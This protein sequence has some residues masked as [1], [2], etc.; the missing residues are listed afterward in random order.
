MKS[1][2][3]FS[4]LKFNFLYFLQRKFEFIKNNKL[5]RAFKLLFLVQV[6]ISTIFLFITSFAITSYA[7]KHID[8][9][10]YYYYLIFFIFIVL[11]P[12]LPRAKMLISPI[13]KDL[14]YRVSIKQSG[15]FNL[16]YVS[17]VLKKLPSYLNFIAI[18][19]GISLNYPNP[20][21]FI[22]KIILALFYFMCISYLVQVIYTNI[23]VKSSKKIL[24]FS[25]FFINIILGISVSTIGFVIS[26]ILLNIF[27]KPFL[28]FSSYII[29]SKEKFEWANYLDSIQ[30]QIINIHNKITMIFD[31]ISPHTIFV[32]VN[33]LNILIVFL[34]FIL[35]ILLYRYN[36]IGYWYRREDDYVSFSN[37]HIPLSTSLFSIQLKQLLNNKEEANLHK[38][39]FYISY[40]LWFFIGSIMYF[41][42]FS[43]NTLANA[44]IFLIILNTVTRDS[45]SAGI[46]LFTK[47]L[48]FDSDGKS[49]GI[50]RISNTSFKKIYDTKIF[51]IRL[52]G[53]KETLIITIFL[54]L[55]LKMDM[56]LYIILGQIIIINTII[57]PNLSLLPSY[58]SPH[59][60]HQH[61]SEFEYF[62]DQNILEDSLFDKIK[63]FISASYFL[64]FFIGYLLQREYVDIMFFI[65]IYNFL[66][67]IIVIYFIKGSKNKITKNW[68]KRDIYL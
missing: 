22:V 18:G 33:V 23:K 66:I 16:I 48:R 28:I 24:S 52:L 49:I 38:P 11:I 54:L 12:I 17:D 14:L 45:F 21:I 63:N 26:F 56:Y 64:I 19:L 44:I 68:E 8:I 42:Q 46:D 39:F 41:S 43:N 9:I 67:F 13:D 40:S 36:L 5:K 7:K 50:Y 25:Y 3:A 53:I 37:R 2:T 34:V 20:L 1:T 4:Y 35:L 51:L 65:I 10:E 30:S 47:S 15:I 31:I 59:F 6:I 58:L 27:I 60:S 32:R 62:E 29:K 61:Y 57:I 55:F